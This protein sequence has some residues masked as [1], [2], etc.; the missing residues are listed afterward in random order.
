MAITIEVSRGRYIRH[1]RDKTGMNQRE[2]MVKV[3]ELLPETEQKTHQWFAAIEVDRIGKMSVPMAI[4]L[5]VVLGADLGS[6][7]ITAAE[8]E[9]HRRLLAMLDDPPSV[10]LPN[11]GR[12]R[13]KRSN[14]CISDRV[15]ARPNAPLKCQPLGGTLLWGRGNAYSS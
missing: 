4:A 12:D 7:G 13:P 15:I 5:N 2:L 14:T 3:N 1:L 9:A 11:R 8:I 10:S 6:L